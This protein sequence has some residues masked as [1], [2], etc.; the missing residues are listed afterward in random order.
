[1]QKIQERVLRFVLKDSVSDYETLLS[2]SELDSFRM[3][4]IKI[5]VV[6]I[7]KILNDMGPRYLSY[8]FSKSITPYQSRD[9]N[10]LIQPLKRT[11]S[12][13]IKS[14]AYF[15]TYLWNMLPQHIKNLVSLYNFKSLIRKWSAP[16]CC[17]SVCMQVVWFR[18]CLYKSISWHMFFLDLLGYIWKRCCHL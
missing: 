7:Y 14:F 3:S 13:R 16:T 18:Y 8:L 15:G 9:D 10:K 12:F 17:C 1:M 5:M 11:T 6:E 4:S 2:K